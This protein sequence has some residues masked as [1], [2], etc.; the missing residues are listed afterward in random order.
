[1]SLYSSSWDGCATV[2]DLVEELSYLGAGYIL[3]E[4][5]IHMLWRHLYCCRQLQAQSGPSSVAT[6]RVCIVFG[7]L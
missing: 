3:N 4:N 2:V 1:M 7:D 5:A 6:L